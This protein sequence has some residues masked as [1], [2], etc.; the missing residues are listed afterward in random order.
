MQARRG[1]AAGLLAGVVVAG[2]AWRLSSDRRPLPDAPALV[3]RVRAIARLETLEVQV[4]KVVAYA[5]D[6]PLASSFAGELVTW[7][8]WSVDPPEGRAMVFA[9]ARLGLELDRL[10]VTSLRVRGDAVE[11]LLPPLVTTVELEPSRTQVI[12]SNLDSTD[13]AALL[14]KAKG[15]LEFEVSR[16]RAL[17]AKGRGAARDALR[18]LLNGLGFREVRFVE[19]GAAGAS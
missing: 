3:E 7:A 13:S 4:S 12:R 11:L 5:P 2:A 19:Q 1:L 6:P 14:G 10:E 18:R 8:R 9:T 16:D 15:E 17:A